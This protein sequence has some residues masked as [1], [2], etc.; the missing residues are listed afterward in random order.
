M[1]RET[2]Y[3]FAQASERPAV[4]DLERVDLKNKL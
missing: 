4:E 3:S 1:S 2:F